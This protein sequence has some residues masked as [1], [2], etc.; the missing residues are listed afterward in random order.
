MHQLGIL[1]H[2][3]GCQC[4]DF[5]DVEALM[6]IACVNAIDLRVHALTPA[7]TRSLGPKPNNLHL[8]FKFEI[9][10]L[11][12]GIAYQNLHNE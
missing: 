11:E 12:D 1:M 2:R 5:N 4:I 9:V 3:L 8:V 10:I 7:C 6:E